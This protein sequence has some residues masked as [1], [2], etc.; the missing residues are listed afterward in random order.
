MFSLAGMF[1]TIASLYNTVE[2]CVMNF[3][4]ECKQI[5]H[6]FQSVLG[7]RA[8]VFFQGF[9]APYWTIMV[10]PSASGSAK[11]EWVYLDDKRIFMEWSAANAADMNQKAKALP[12]LSLE[13]VHKDKVL[14]DLTDFIEGVRVYHTAGLFPSLQHILAAWGLSS[15]II[16]DSA[17]GFEYRIIC[18]VANTHI[19]TSPTEEG[20]DKVIKEK[21]AVVLPASEDEGPWCE[22][23]RHA[24]ELSWGG[25]ESKADVSEYED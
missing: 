25:E 22:E 20:I 12:I 6:A 3:I 13:V 9:A 24:E 14:Y 1:I 18:N 21:K 2:S 10:N 16:L 19:I 8:Y 4:Y 15:G 23:G 17:R 7:P 11:P 5:W